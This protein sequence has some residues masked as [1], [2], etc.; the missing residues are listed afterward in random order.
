M[1]K[2]AKDWLVYI[3]QCSDG[4]Y[5][6]GCTNNLEKRVQVHNDGKGARYTRGRGPVLVLAYRDGLTHSQ[7]C[8]LE[9]L[10]KRKARHLKIKAL[11]EISFA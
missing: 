7:A 6:C 5:Y 2:N 9:R 1:A 4:S 10:V 3:L 11:N 8:K